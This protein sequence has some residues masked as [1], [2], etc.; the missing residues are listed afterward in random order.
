MSSNMLGIWIIGSLVGLLGLIGLFLSAYA[1]DGVMHV[2]GLVIALFS[3]VFVFSLIGGHAD[4]PA[5][6]SAAGE[7]ADGAGHDE[8]IR[9]LAAEARVGAAELVDATVEPG[10]VVVGALD[11]RSD[12]LV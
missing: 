9:P 3:V 11:K 8:E 1:V 5:E 7:G 2:T 4:E 6:A 10:E 12:A